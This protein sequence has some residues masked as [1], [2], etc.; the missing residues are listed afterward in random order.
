MTEAIHHDAKAR[1][2]SLVIEGAEAYLTYE[3]PRPG[4]RHITH[5]IVPDA[6]GGRGIGKRLVARIMEDVAA[7]GETVSSSCWY[8]SGLI[9]KTPAWR[10]RL[11]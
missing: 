3:T 5:T 10:E 8:A 4:H 7:A 6:V 2:Y 9:E 1:R 11:G